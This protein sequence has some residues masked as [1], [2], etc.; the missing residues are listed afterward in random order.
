MKNSNIFLRL[1]KL[2]DLTKIQNMF[3]ETITSV[4]TVDYDEQQIKVWALG[5]NNK[6][7]WKDIMTK[8]FVLVAEH[9]EKIVG[10]ATLAN[11]SY[12]DLLYVHKDYQRQGIAK[13]LLDEITKEAIR[14][15]TTTLKSDVSKTAKPFFAIN[16]FEQLKE[17]M[18]LR[19]GVALINYKMTKQL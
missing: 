12:I 9:T 13:L 17:Q 2:D 4:C 8:Q 18:S 6:E 14:L 5:V 11:G 16:G 19:Q 15:G 10:F 3:V 7:R 1:A